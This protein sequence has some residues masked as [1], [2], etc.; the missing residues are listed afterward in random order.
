MKKL[1]HRYKKWLLFRSGFRKNGPSRRANLKYCESVI[2]WSS[3]QNEKLISRRPPTFPPTILCFEKNP[4][5]TIDFFAEWRRKNA[6]Y[7]RGGRKHWVKRSKHKRPSIEG[8]IDY[9]KIEEISTAAS[10][11]MAA[12]YDRARRLMGEVPPAINLHKWSADAFQKLF[13]MGF[14]EIVGISADASDRFSQKG[15]VRTMRIATGRDASELEAVCGMILELS[16]FIDDSGPLPRDTYVALNTALSEAISNVTRWAYPDDIALPYKHISSWW[17]TATANRDDRTLTVVVFDQGATVPVTFP[18]KPAG[19]MIRDK[20]L[21]M[22]SGP[23]HHFAD[24]GT[25]IAA[26]MK[27]GATSTDHSWHGKGLP[28]M[29]DLIKLCRGGSVSILSRGGECLVNHDGFQSNQSRQSSV[30]GTLITWK[31]VLPKET[32]NA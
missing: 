29:V 23:R 7:W 26:A 20:I 25:Y 13:A 21:R 8:Y 18:R 3:D 31:L 19:I 5:A 28:Q 9:S 32:A 30:G 22:F 24:D 27:P 10:V 14:F 17:I 1:S 15:D 11:V 6:I 16:K 12:E 4:E 2:A